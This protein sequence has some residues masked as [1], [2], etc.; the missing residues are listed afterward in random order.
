M[1][2]TIYDLS[3]TSKEPRQQVEEHLHGAATIADNRPGAVYQRKLH[4][5]MN[6]PLKPD[7]QFSKRSDGLPIQ[8]KTG[9]ENLSGYSMD[10]VKVHYN[11]SK[12]A[13]LRAHAYAQGTDIHLAPGQER[14]LPHEAWH[15]VQ[16]KQ[17]R[18]RPTFQFKRGVNINDDV[19]LEREAD[20]MGE[21]AL[22][23][24][25]EQVENSGN[26]GLVSEKVH[27]S[28]IQRKDIYEDENLIIK[29]NARFRNKKYKDFIRLIKDAY[30]E[31]RTNLTKILIDLN[32]VNGMQVKE[33]S[34]NRKSPVFIILQES[35]GL[36][37][38]NFTLT[39]R[40]LPYII[41]TFSRVK[42]GLE[43]SPIT[44]EISSAIG[45][46]VLGLVKQI[47]LEE[48]SKKVGYSKHSEEAFKRKNKKVKGVKNIDKVTIKKDP[49]IKGEN[50]SS[51]KFLQDSDELKQING[52]RLYLNMN[53]LSGNEKKTKGAVRD[54]FMHELTHYFAGTHDNFYSTGPTTAKDNEFD[55]KY[56]VAN[57]DTYAYLFKRYIESK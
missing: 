5:T 48:H 15:V 17:G 50:I 11:S 32:R 9:I 12:P 13:Q 51:F 47:E 4:E 43:G 57:A 42:T 41:Q 34:R 20:V 56:S 49:F 36:P 46:D 52:D 7:P 19:I 40:Y 14:H 18:V 28:T 45:R 2:K 24:H 21:K 37:I 26:P 30:E 22:K 29:S 55:I 1:N 31:I 35:F 8:L 54:T 23:S 10:D 16:Q 6:H 25:H 38:N 27:S 53:I 39:K 3:A 44:V 33:Y